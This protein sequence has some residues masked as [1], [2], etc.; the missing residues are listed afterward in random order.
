MKKVKI[1][2][3]LILVAISFMTSVEV[4]E[5]AKRTSTLHTTL[6]GLLYAFITVSSLYPGI[7]MISYVIEMQLFSGMT[8]LLSD[9]SEQIKE[10]MGNECLDEHFKKGLRIE[11]LIGMANKLFGNNLMFDFAISLYSLVFAAFFGML[12]FTAFSSSDGVY[13]NVLFF[14]IGCLCWTVFLVLRLGSLVHAGQRLTDACNEAARQ[15]LG[16]YAR[17]K[18]EGDAEAEAWVLRRRLLVD[19]AITPGRVFHLGLTSGLSAV[20]MIIT[21]IFVLLQLRNGDNKIGGGGGGVGEH[22]DL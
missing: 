18:A 13:K 7:M 9:F 21:D 19:A 12:T 16:A 5:F 1:H 10:S 15:V 8:M 4:M 14:G 11:R 20:N 22:V 2:Y 17:D 6:H 3:A